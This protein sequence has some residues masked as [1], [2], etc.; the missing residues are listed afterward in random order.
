MDPKT[1]AQ[2]RQEIA[3]AWALVDRYKRAS[4][5]Y[6]MERDHAKLCYERTVRI[7]SGIHNVLNP[8]RFTKPDGVTMEF[9][10]PNAHEQLQELSDRIRAI[11]EK[12]EEVGEDED[13]PFDNAEII[14]R[15]RAANRK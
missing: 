1:E 9:I 4:E 6:A 5:V 15:L 8:P 12:L 13:A 7:L 10:S 14:A 3:E 2:L 11:P